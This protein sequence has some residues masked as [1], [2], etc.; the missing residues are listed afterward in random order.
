MLY[1]ALEEYFFNFGHTKVTNNDFYKYYYSKYEKLSINEFKEALKNLIVEERVLLFDNKT[2][3]TTFKIREME[4]Y[5]VSRL[6]DIKKS[7]Q[8]NLIN[9]K[10]KTYISYKTKQLI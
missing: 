8:K 4:E 10:I 9:L 7:E 6:Y 1:I 3:L 5:V 2:Y